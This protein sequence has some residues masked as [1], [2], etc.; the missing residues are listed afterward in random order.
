MKTPGARAGLGES[1][2]LSLTTNSV[3]AKIPR[4]HPE[5]A[6]TTVVV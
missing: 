3:S 4:G 1:H 2:T 5:V 6:C